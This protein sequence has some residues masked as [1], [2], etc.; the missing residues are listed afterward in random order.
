MRANCSTRCPRTQGDRSARHGVVEGLH[1]ERADV[2]GRAERP[3]GFG[4]EALQGGFTLWNRRADA[5]VVLT[6]DLRG[7]SAG[8]EGSR[9][10][11]ARASLLADTATGTATATA[12]RCASRRFAPASSTPTAAS[13]RGPDLSGGVFV[14][15]GVVV[16]E[17]V[18]EG[19]VTTLGSHTATARPASGSRNRCPRSRS[20]A[21]SV[22]RAARV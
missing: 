20:A 18:N 10:C 9:R 7:I 14:I 8:S 11:G 5:G 13:P 12:V 21:T 15:P 17:V 1:V 22:L 6:A 16:D 4:V 19:P 2:R 3:H